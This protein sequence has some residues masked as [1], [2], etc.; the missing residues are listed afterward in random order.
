MG[1]KGRDRSQRRRGFDDEAEPAAPAY[2]GRSRQPFRAGPRENAAPSGPPIDAVVKWFNPDKGFGFCELADGSGDAFLH[3]A[4]LEAA[5]HATVDPG[6]K[7]SVQVGVGQKGRQVTAVLS[8]A[9]GSGTA[10]PRAGARPPP[11]ASSGRERPDPATAT[12]IEG[13][14]KWFNP[15]KGFGFVA[16]ED[17]EK[18]VFVHA[19]VV[20]RAGL[21]GLDEGQRLAMK[22]V[23]TQKGREAIS[24]TL[25]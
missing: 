6:A 4:V 2:E 21:R 3:A 8:V 25:I 18:D 23:K 13:T 20:E 5:G 9:A 7:L 22:V 16:C 24:I 15:D 11:R 19:S 12:S 17:G 10:A 14:V 1:Q